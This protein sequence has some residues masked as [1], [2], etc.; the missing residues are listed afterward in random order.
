VIVA[1][2]SCERWTIATE[3]RGGSAFMEVTGGVAERSKSWLYEGR[4]F[5]N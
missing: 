5:S 4:A 2:D 1:D 3:G